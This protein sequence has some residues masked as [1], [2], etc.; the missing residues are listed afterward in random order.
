M[1][2]IRPKMIE[3]RSFPSRCRAELAVLSM[4]SQLRSSLQPKNGFIQP[5]GML[6]AIMSGETL[7][8]AMMPM[9]KAVS[10]RM[11]NW[12]TSVMTTLTIPPLMA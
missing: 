8:S 12:A 6:C 3:N 2:N 11:V 4:P 7:T 9:A 10:V 5:A 1:K